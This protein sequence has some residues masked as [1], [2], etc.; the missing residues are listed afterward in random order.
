MSRNINE[1]KQGTGFRI[2]TLKQMFR[3]LPLL[4]SEISA[5][6]KS[7]SLLNEIRQILCSLYRSKEIT[8]S[9]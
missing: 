6:N 3:R 8:K 2:I 7:E 1:S 9:V 5:G 4:L